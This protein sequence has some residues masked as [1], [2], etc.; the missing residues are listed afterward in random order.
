MQGVWRR[1]L[2]LCQPAS[3]PLRQ[4][5]STSRPPTALKSTQAVALS[6]AAGA[7]QLSQKHSAVT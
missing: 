6:S 3:A 4:R 5:R 1:A 7:Q 2:W